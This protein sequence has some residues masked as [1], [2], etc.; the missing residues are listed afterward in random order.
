LTLVRDFPAV[1]RGEY[2]R[3]QKMYEV[4]HLVRNQDTSSVILMGHLTVNKGHSRFEVG[5]KDAP[6]SMRLRAYC[7][8]AVTMPPG[9]SF[10]GE[11]LLVHLGGDGLRAL[12]HLGDLIGAANDIRLKEKRPLNLED[13]SLL[14]FTHTRW[15]GWMSGGTAAQAT[16]FIKD[17]GLDKF[18]YGTGQGD[19]EIG[20]QVSWGVAHA[21]G[22][23]S[24]RGGTSAYPA[25]CYLPVNVPWGNGKV[26]DFSNPVCVEAEKQRIAAAFAG[27]EDKVNLGEVDYSEIWDKWPGQHDP[28]LSA[29]ETWHAAVSPWRDF[30]DA[31]SPRMRNHSCMTKLDFN[32]GYIDFARVAEDSDGMNVPDTS[33]FKVDGFKLIA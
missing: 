9:R 26:L 29:V 19:P 32:Y 23:G 33:P 11:R 17:N 24:G 6:D 5:R 14:S 7:T 3:P 16:Q 13:R 4:C 28:F 12:E 20:R 15:I 30:I 25:E 22:G 8:Y 2:R 1:N 27:K 10:T 31:K 21:G 18:Y